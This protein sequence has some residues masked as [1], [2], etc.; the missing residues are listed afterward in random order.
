MIP[1]QQPVADKLT[2]LRDLTRNTVTRTG[3]NGEKQT[4]SILDDLIYRYQLHALTDLT[5]PSR[6]DGYPTRASGSDTGQGSGSYVIVTHDD[7]PDI[8]M[9]DTV[10]VPVTGPEATLL[11]QAGWRDRHRYLTSNATHRLAEAVGALLAFQQIIE[12]LEQEQRPEI[13][14]SEERAEY[15]DAWCVSHLRFQILEPR[16]ERRGTKACAW[17]QSF[18]A[19]VGTYPPKDLVVKHDH[20]DRIYDRDIR[21]HFPDYGQPVHRTK[22][23]RRKGRAA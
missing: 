1:E 20:G 11:A 4:I 19:D 10:R 21:K 8:P 22:T 13:L 3:D 15:E 17:C 14:S 7:D 5:S 9:G 23:R 12:R 18:R 16:D 2:R 6:P